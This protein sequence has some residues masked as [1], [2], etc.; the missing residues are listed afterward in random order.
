[1]VIGDY[2]S[3]PQCLKNPFCVQTASLPNGIP[4]HKLFVFDGFGQD[5][6]HPLGRKWHLTFYPL[7]SKGFTHLGLT[8]EHYCHRF[9]VVPPSK[10]SNKIYVLGKNRAY[11]HRPSPVLWRPTVF[12]EITN[13]TGISFTIGTVQKSIATLHGD[14]RD[15]LWAGLNDIGSLSRDNF[16][17]RIQHHRAIFGLGWPTQPST[18]LEGLCVG[19]PFINPVWS[20]MK[21]EPDR[22][23]WNTQHPYLVHF[24]PPYVYNV[25]GHREEMILEAVKAI[26]KNPLK[27]GFIPEEMKKETYLARFV[28]VPFVTF[29]VR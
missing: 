16:I 24:D 10:R 26:R 21:S 8:L 22:S 18:P 19:T 25:Q 28:E 29:T 11:L 20:E 15:E 17:K 14:E 23:K 3:I 2:L 12:Q 7:E 5:V 4:V 9:G 27:K 1:M 6:G 13:A